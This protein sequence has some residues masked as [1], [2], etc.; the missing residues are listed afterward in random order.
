[1]MQL[2]VS[3]LLLRTGGGTFSYALTYLVVFEKI[4]GRLYIQKVCMEV[5]P[6]HAD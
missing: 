6:L 4:D 5:V 1:M 2:Q 3:L